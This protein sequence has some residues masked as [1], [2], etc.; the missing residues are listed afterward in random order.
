MTEEGFSDIL[1]EDEDA[2][3]FCE[4]DLEVYDMTTLSSTPCPYCLPPIS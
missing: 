3:F 4:G 1:K 2:C